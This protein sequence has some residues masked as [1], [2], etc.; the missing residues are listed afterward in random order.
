MAIYIDFDL[1]NKTKEVFGVFGTFI[2]VKM[3]YLKQ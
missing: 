2:G 1:P 3:D